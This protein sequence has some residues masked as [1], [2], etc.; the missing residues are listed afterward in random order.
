MHIFADDIAPRYV[1]SML[2]LDRDTVAVSDKF[3]NFAALRLPKDVSDEIESDISGGKHA[4]LTS[5]AA[6]GALNGANNKLQ[7]CAQFHVG[8]VIC[9]L[10]KCALQTGGSEVIVYATLGGALGAFV[11]FASKDEA[12]FC[13]HL[14]MH[15]RIEAPPVLGNEH[16]AF[17]SSYFPVKAVVDGDLCEQFGR[18]GADAQRRISEEM[19]RTPSEIVKRLEQIRARAG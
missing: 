13:T 19:D 15:L 12:D 2:P 11:P 1:T 6:L 4:A 17:R 18:L 14:E 9:S 10:T 3:G 7:A 16:G 5:S 8:D